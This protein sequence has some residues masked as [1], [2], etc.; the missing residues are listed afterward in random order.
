MSKFLSAVAGLLLVTA[1]TTATA[2]E[3]IEKPLV[4]QSLD[5]FH[6]EAGSIRDG[7][8]PGGRYEFVKAGDR[9]RVEARLN[10]MESVLQ[11]NAEKN[12]LGTAD[13]IALANA[14][15]EVNSILK[16]NDSNRLVCESKAPIGSHLPVKTCR[17]FGEIEQGRRD[18]VRSV[19][20]MDRAR[21]GTHGN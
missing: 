5:G 7:L 8:K 19:S 9:D 17:T 13:K 3:A 4:A 14:Q 2:Q 21:V 18:A 16:H 20:E 12:D 1:A 6:R 15:E 11:K 10:T